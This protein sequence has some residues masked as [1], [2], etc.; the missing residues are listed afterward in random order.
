MCVTF[1]ITG[2][3]ERPQ[4]FQLVDVT[5]NALK[6]AQPMCSAMFQYHFWLGCKKGTP[7]INELLLTL[8]AMMK[9]I[10]NIYKQFINIQ[11]KGT[12]ASFDSEICQVADTSNITKGG[13]LVFNQPLHS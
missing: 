5:A 11:G 7:Q 3:K 10:K 9:V 8:T 4:P 2:S 13:I 1:F 6:Q 12:H